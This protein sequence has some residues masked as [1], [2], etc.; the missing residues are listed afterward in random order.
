[1]KTPINTVALNFIAPAI[2]DNKGNYHFGRFIGTIA[3]ITSVQEV[4]GHMEPDIDLFLGYQLV[5]GR[6]VYLDHFDTTKPQTLHSLKGELY[7]LWWG[8]YP[9]EFPEKWKAIKTIPV[10]KDGDGVIEELPF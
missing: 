10:A 9:R 3:L 7:S 4:E 8:A 5:S 2:I 6:I 1:M